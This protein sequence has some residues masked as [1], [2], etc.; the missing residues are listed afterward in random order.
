MPFFIA[1]VVLPL[2]AWSSA[3]SAQEL[4]VVAGRADGSPLIDG[5]LSDWRE[6]P[7]IRLEDWKKLLLARPAYL[8]ADIFLRWDETYLYLAAK[9]WDPIHCQP[10]AGEGVADGDGIRFGIA[11]EG[12]WKEV[13]LAL[14]AEGPVCVF[15]NVSRTPEGKPVASYGGTMEGVRLAVVRTEKETI[16][17]AAIPAQALSV[18]AF[19]EGQTFQFS[20]LVADKATPRGLLTELAWAGGLAADSRSIEQYGKLAL[21]AQ[22]TNEPISLVQPGILPNF[23]FEYVDQTK[24]PYEWVRTWAGTGRTKNWTDD[25][26]ATTQDAYSGEV[27]VRIAAVSKEATIIVF[28]RQAVRVRPNARYT[29]IIHNRTTMK[30]GINGAVVHLENEQEPIEIDLGLDHGWKEKV[31]QFEAGPKTSWLIFSFFAGQ[32][33]GGESYFD[34]IILR[35]EPDAPRRAVVLTD[36]PAGPFARCVEAMFPGG[37]KVIDLTEDK[38]TERTLR[39]Y[40]CAVVNVAS[41]ESVPRLDQKVID[42]YCRA[43]GLFL[44]ALDEYAILRGVH[45]NVSGIPEAAVSADGHGEAPSVEIRKSC[46]LTDGFPVGSIVPWYGTRDGVLIQK[47]LL[48]LPRGAEVVAVSSANGFPVF[49]ME[50]K[51]KGALFAVDLSSLD[52]PDLSFGNRGSLHKY[53]LVANLAAGGGW[54]ASYPLKK[55]SWDEITG[56]MQALSKQYRDVR[57]SVEGMSGGFP[58]LSLSLGTPGK[59]VLLIACAEGSADG[60]AAAAGCLSVVEYLAKHR[61]VPEV[62]GKLAS[63][64]IKVIPVLNPARYIS[65]QTGQQPAPPQKVA[66]P[67]KPLKEGELA[68]ILVLR[69]PATVPAEVFVLPAGKADGESAAR[70]SGKA[71]ELLARRFIFWDRNWQEP[72]GLWP[73]KVVSAEKAEEA[74]GALLASLS[75]TLGTPVERLSAAQVYLVTADRPGTT[76]KEDLSAGLVSAEVAGRWALAA[77][78]FLP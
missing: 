62:S 49:V 52:E 29:L 24:M 74:S 39:G 33:V 16:Y 57:L 35:E 50:P 54:M 59:P 27:S 45:L 72:C 11:G 2:L 46:R 64:H 43:G 4:R 21:I 8:R 10:H 38:L 42:A 9:V 12:F 22:R 30:E 73:A 19:A 28:P 61:A 63:Y 55:L 66:V 69:L 67:V 13:S 68:W 65:E 37:V 15:W 44:M 17:E 14:T 6:D 76:G 34:D 58:V 51:G 25:V 3:I 41:I 20:C 77:V 31:V 53:L 78:E 18:K 23:S 7:A 5:D 47:Q 26:G 32:A 56:R 60:W 71:E 1:F 36:N 48:K 40:P 70:L 75:D